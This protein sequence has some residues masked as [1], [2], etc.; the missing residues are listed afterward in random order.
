VP[1]AD[2]GTASTTLRTCGPRGIILMKRGTKKPSNSAIFSG[3]GLQGHG[4]VIAAK[5]IA[6]REAL[7]PE[8]RFTSSRF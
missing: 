7:T 1:H 5:A 4:H 6:F 2:V 3:P 8:F